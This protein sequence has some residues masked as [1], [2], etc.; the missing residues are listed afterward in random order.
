MHTAAYAETTTA[1]TRAHHG[2]T[3]AG[4]IASRMRANGLPPPERGSSKRSQSTA[5]T[6]AATPE[7]T[8]VLSMR[9]L[10]DER[11][12]QGCREIVARANGG[13]SDAGCVQAQQ[14]RL[15]HSPRAV[16]A[17]RVD[18]DERHHA[19]GQ[20]PLNE[21]VDERRLESRGHDH[22]LERTCCRP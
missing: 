4:A 16:E 21:A 3:S 18:I 1:A 9:G 20:R 5:I 17:R 7:R 14:Q 13:N 12:F 22:E 11:A 2:R 6:S 8:T 10:G 19:P 15:R